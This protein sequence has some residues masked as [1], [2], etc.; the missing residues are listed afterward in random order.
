MKQTKA[1]SAKPHG[2]KG[3]AFTS[4][5]WAEGTVENKSA[6]PT[7]SG[8]FTKEHSF[9][10]KGIAI[11]MMMWHHCF[12]AG[13]F[14]QYTVDFWPLAQGQAVN[15]A[16]FCKMC[17]SLF[18]FI[19]GY[20]LYLT[21]KKA[22]KRNVSA[23]R[24][25]Y[26]RLV[27]TL[28]GYWFVVVLSWVACTFLDNR[29]YQVYGFEKSP[30][31]GLWNMLMEFLG[32]T[33]L[34]GGQLLSEDWWYMSAAVVFILLLPL[35]CK[36]FEHIGCLC[37]LSI[38]LILPRLSMGFPGWVHFYAFLPIFCL[39]MIFARY[40]L[41]ARWDRL[42]DGKPVW[43]RTLKVFAM[44]AGM[45]VIYK[46]SY[47]LKTDVWWD[48]KWNFFPLLTIFFFR[49][50]LFRIPIF[51]KPLL[52]LGKHA[53]NIFLIHTFIRYYYCEAF[54][55]GQEYFL[56]IMGVLLLTSLALSIALEWVK[57]TVHYDRW[58]GM[59]VTVPDRSPK[60]R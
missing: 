44:L 43:L 17:V 7:S 46:L 50:Y 37:T 25:A 36:G 42:W 20:G 8:A 29:P 9:A 35:L 22:E 6:Q 41:F 16:N 31:L 14:E 59:L 19:S 28:S 1:V 32:L 57:K 33:N 13:R 18:V 24:W 51:N 49:D 52:F 23:N 45:L 47:N 26:E 4:S 15:I 12:L 2:G 40:D 11:L 53:T 30:L 10:L 3:S 56:R 5:A 54:I 27:R 58:I 60:K 48:V 34:T 38:I 39:G 21:W 55:Y